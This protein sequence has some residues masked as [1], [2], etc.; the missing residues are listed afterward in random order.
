MVEHME[1]GSYGPGTPAKRELFSFMKSI[2]ERLVFAHL[3][4]CH[5]PLGAVGITDGQGLGGM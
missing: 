5:Q 1:S 4:A 3:E 2:W